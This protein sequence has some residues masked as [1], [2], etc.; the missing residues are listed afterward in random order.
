M[1]RS[2]KNGLDEEISPNADNHSREVEHPY[3]SCGRSVVIAT[4]P[5]GDG[6]LLLS[7]HGLSPD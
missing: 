7:T 5:A 4:E 2:S 3:D 1:I 6:C